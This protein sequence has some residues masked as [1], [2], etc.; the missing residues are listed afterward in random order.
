MLAG[1]VVD[2]FSRDAVTWVRSTTAP[3][4]GLVKYTDGTKRC[5][6]SRLCAFTHERG[7]WG[8]SYHVSMNQRRLRL[9]RLTVC[10]CVGDWACCMRSYMRRRERPQLLLSA[11]G[12]PRYYSS[13]VEDVEDH[14]FTLVVKVVAR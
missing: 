2:A 6:V 4:T 3:V 14:S 13:G 12:Q 8:K 1:V 7:G 10:A 5:V 11:Q 9:R